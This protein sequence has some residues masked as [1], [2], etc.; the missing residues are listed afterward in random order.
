MFCL[1]I[2]Q[3]TLLYLYSYKIDVF[4]NEINFLNA[5]KLLGKLKKLNL[6]SNLY[7][8]QLL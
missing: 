6:H 8:S 4:L 1:C 3:S 7:K 5:K 2:V